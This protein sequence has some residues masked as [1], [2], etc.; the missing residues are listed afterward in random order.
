MQK[1]FKKIQ[2]VKAEIGKMPK[3]KVNPFHNKKYFDINVLLEHLEPLLQK[4]NLLLMQP[5]DG[6]VITSCI[7]DLDGTQDDVVCSSM[8]LPEMGDP[9]K[10]G[11]AVTYYRRY[12]LTSLLSLQAEDDDGN[13]ASNKSVKAPA[14]KNQVP[15]NQEPQDPKFDNGKQ[16]DKWIKENDKLWMRA[17]EKEMSLQELRTYV[18]VSKENAEKYLEALTSK[19]ES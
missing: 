18:K 15:E 13:Q 16:L 14:K 5:I 8:N 10:M 11:S 6:N 4:Q 3:D 2:A 17:L 19:I 7:Y 12:T 9:Q 1:L